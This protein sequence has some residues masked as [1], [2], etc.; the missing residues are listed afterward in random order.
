MFGEESRYIGNFSILCFH[1]NINSFFQHNR[2]NIIFRDKFSHCIHL[3]DFL[4]LGLYAISE[5]YL[6][7]PSHLK[8]KRQEKDRSPRCYKYILLAELN[9]LDKRK[10]LNH[11][12]VKKKKILK[13]KKKQKLVAVSLVALQ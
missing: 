10:H 4:N 9:S 1:L 13:G 6:S 3:L 5:M 7:P 11:L 8:M 2:T 12:K